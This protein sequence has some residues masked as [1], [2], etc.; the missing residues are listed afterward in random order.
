MEAIKMTKP[1]VQDNPGTIPLPLVGWPEVPDRLPTTMAATVFGSFGGPEVLE[2]TVVKLP[3]VG[4]EDV[5]VRVGA[6]SVGRL[7]DLSSRAGTHPYAGFTLP[8]V[9]GAEHAGTVV[10]IGSG[11]SGVA[12]GDA[13]AV[14]PSI[15]CGEC[16]VCLS[17]RTEACSRLQIIGVH[18]QGAYA[19]YTAVPATNVHVISGAAAGQLGPATAAAL[20]LSGPVSMHQLREAGL[21]PGDWVLVQGAASALGSVT[22]ALA[23][24][25]GARVIGTSRS[26]AK[27]AVLERLGVDA[28]LDSRAGDLVEQVLT[29][30]QGR[31]VAVVIDDLGDPEI[32]AASA[33]CLATLGTIVTSGAFLGGKVELDLA[34]L[35][36]R[37]QRV[38]GVRTGT[39]DAIEALWRE[40]DAGFRPL[41]DAAFPLERASDAHRHLEGDSGTGRVV[42]VPPGAITDPAPEGALED[43]G[44]RP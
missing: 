9:L 8:H 36:L 4:A 32:F 44:V 6:V 22:A 5:L 23:V 30:T 21:R 17:G 19:E 28:V 34:R 35:Y 37:S 1:L 42:L 29:L 18:R 40:V 27:R 39:K 10:Q 3:T 41:V 12:V 15:T 2:P 7:L 14:Y 13:V 24:H 20:A 33:A 38:I 31:G 26:A 16:E 43:V 25:L 11:V